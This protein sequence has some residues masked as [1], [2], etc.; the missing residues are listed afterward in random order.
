MTHYLIEFRFQG[1]AKHEIRELVY[2]IRNRFNLRG[3][4]AV[5]HI[6]LAGPLSTNDEKRLIGELNR[7]C[8]KS[9]LMSFQVEG[10]SV[11]KETGVVFLDIKPS[12][13]LKEFRWKLSRKLQSYC[14]LSKY[15]YDKNFDFHA[16]IAMKLP[17]RK[18]E[19]IS[20]YLEEKHKVGFRHILIRATIIKNKKILREYDFFLRRPLT[21]KL[22]LNRRVKAKT[23]SL[24][25]AYFIGRFN[26]DEFFGR[27]SFRI[28]KKKA[29][30][31]L[32]D[33][34]RKPKIFITSDLHM[35]HKNIMKY[36]VRPFLAV[37]DM[38]RTLVNNWNNTVSKKDTVYF[39]GDLAFG[40]G[41]RSTD[42][43][44]KKLNGKIVFLKGNHDKSS[45]IKFHDN[46]TLE[47][48]GY[49]FF[50]THEPES[51]PEEWDGWAI[52][53]HHHNNKMD[54]YPFFDRENRRFNVSTE[55]TKFCPIEM[56][57]LIRQI[58]E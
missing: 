15:D 3:K 31:K 19:Q 24:L 7:L 45:K 41:S 36:C 57:D 26:P 33:M 23:F 28:K 18:L 40:R 52:C 25:E 6:T 10:F 54:E 29:I 12:E 5:P 38:N 44:M 34:F 20:K 35:D 50:L 30:D 14:E 16:T 55:L 47:Y 37:E 9:P 2:D 13:E 11:F 22:A 4:R 48:R 43:W 51:I 46:Y 56:D 1:K 32:I 8:G 39:L 27:F 42:Y 49:K 58:Q 17:D 53:G 21:R